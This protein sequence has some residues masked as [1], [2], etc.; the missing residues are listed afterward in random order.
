[1]KYL[2]AF[3]LGCLALTAF[4]YKAQASAFGFIGLGFGLGILTMAL[5]NRLRPGKVYRRRH[6][7]A[8]RASIVDGGRIQPAKVFNG[9]IEQSARRR[10]AP[11]SNFRPPARS[12]V[13]SDV[14]SALV[15]FGLRKME[16]QKTVA[17]VGRPDLPFQD[18]FKAATLRVSAR[19]KR[20]D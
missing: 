16:A 10:C 6:H 15:N 12:A 14:V 9:T 19:Q 20:S 17:A 18:L 11:P 8:R 5:V 2:G 3:L 1:M 13:E 4:A 7:G